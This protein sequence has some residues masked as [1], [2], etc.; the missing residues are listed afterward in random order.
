MKS[1]R[2]LFFLV[3]LL[4]VLVFS[5][6]AN[7][8]ASNKTAQDEKGITVPENAPE[9]APKD[10]LYNRPRFEVVAAAYNALQGRG[11]SDLRENYFKEISTEKRV[12]EN[13]IPADISEDVIRVLVRERVE[14]QRSGS[15]KGV[16]VS[17]NA[18]FSKIVSSAYLNGIDCP[19]TANALRW[20]FFKDLDVALG[21]KSL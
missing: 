16:V 13:P 5:G 8:P 11:F 17:F 14:I 7:Q 9:N 19:A 4:S 18:C 1:W 21:E 20:Q 3:C 10:K 6:C 15:G 2:S 12:V